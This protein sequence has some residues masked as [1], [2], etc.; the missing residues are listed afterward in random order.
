MHKSGHRGPSLEIVLA[1]VR[2]N[3]VNHYKHAPIAHFRF[4]VRAAALSEVGKAS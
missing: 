4:P 2:L 3:E 1:G